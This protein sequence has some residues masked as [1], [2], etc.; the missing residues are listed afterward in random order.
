MQDR[1]KHFVERNAEN[2]RF[3][4]RAA[5]IGRVVNCILTLSNVRDGKDREAVHFIVVTGVVTVRA[6][7]CHFARLDI[8]F[9]HDLRAGGHFQIVGNTLHHFGPGAAQ[10]SGEGI[11]REG[12][13]YRRNGTQNGGRIGTQRDGNR[14]AFARMGCAPLLIIKRAAAMRQPAHDQFVFANQLLAIDTEILTLFM[15]TARNGQAPGYQRRGIFWPALHNG[16]TR[17][18]DRLTFHDF[19]LAR[20]A[21]QPFGRHVQHLLKLR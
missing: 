18:I 20:C 16:D 19:L 11:F 3:I 17:Q 4:R 2:G 14:E 1:H 12:I 15:R 5:R 7:W 10:Q 9:K 21:T 8:A 6:F 13:R